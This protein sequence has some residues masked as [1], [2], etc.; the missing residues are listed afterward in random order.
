MTEKELKDLIDAYLEEHGND[1]TYEV[2]V[3]LLDFFRIKYKKK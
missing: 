2:M 1:C 3:E